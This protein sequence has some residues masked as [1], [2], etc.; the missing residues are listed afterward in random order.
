MVTG[1][2]H[3]YVSRSNYTI[4]ILD[5][6]KFRAPT[7]ICFILC[8]G[9]DGPYVIKKMMMDEKTTTTTRTVRPAASSATRELDD[10]MATLS[11]FK[12]STH[13]IRSNND[14]IFVGVLNF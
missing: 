6:F 5:S 7:K 2:D 4:F 13:K 10:L 12:V 3:Q 9:T 11:D 14:L 1:S 8:S